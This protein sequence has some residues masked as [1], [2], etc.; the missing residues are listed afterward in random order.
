MKLLL[1]NPRLVAGAEEANLSTLRAL[2][3]PFRGSMGPNDLAL[4]P[5]HHYF[6]AWEAYLDDMRELAAWLRSTLIA[7]AS[8]MT[9]SV[10]SL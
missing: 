8:R 3:A 4:L 2:L 1:V 5:E 9:F 10:I 7:G 6:G